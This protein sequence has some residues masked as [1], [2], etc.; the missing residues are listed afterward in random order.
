M[1]EKT[2]ITLDFPKILKKLAGY[3]AFSASE[4]LALGLTP[5]VDLDEVHR[6]LSGTSEARYLLSLIPAFSVGGVHDIRPMAEKASRSGVLEPS[7]LLDIKSTLVSS[8]DIARIFT[9]H[10][11]EF[12]LLAE[13]TEI[14]VP[15]PGIVDAITKIVSDQG[16]ILDNASQRL[17]AIRSEI[18]VAHERLL[19]RLERYISDPKTAPLLQ[20]P[21]FT[22]RNNRYVIPLRADFKGRIPAVVHDQSSSGAT[23]FIEPLAVVELNNRW[24]ELQLEERDEIRRILAQLSLQIGV[25]AEHITQMVRALAELD[26]SLMQAK[27]ADDID[28]NEPILVPVKEDLPDHPGC[29]IRLYQARHPLLPAQ[30]VVPIDVV[31]DEQTFSMVITG[32]NTGGKTVTLKTVGLLILMAQTGL[33][34]PVLSGSILSIFKNVF[35]D[36]G[37]EQ[38][39]EQSLS[40]FSGHI[41]NIIRILPQSNEHT[42]LLLDELGAGTDPQDGAAIAQGILTYLIQRRIPNLIATHYPELKS[43]AHLTPGTTNASVD[44]DLK[45]L[46]PTYHLTI[47][48]PGKSNALLIAERLGLPGEIL[49]SARAQRNPLDLRSEDLLE[50]ILRQ[51][52]NARQERIEAEKMRKD[53]QEL[54]RALEKRLDNIEEERLAVLNEA[55]QEISQ[56]IAEVEEELE[57]LRR[58]IKKRR[59]ASEEVKE[60]QT[61]LEDVKAELSH[62]AKRTTTRQKRPKR[63]YKV[64][65]RV[66][67]RSLGM[68]GVITSIDDDEEVEVQAGALRVRAQTAD[69]QIVSEGGKNETT[70][71]TE[72]A[73]LSY[74]G[75]VS[76]I[77]P[78]PG[79]ELDLRG[80]KSDEARDRLQAYLEDAYLAGLPMVRIIHGKGTGKLRETVREV[81]QRSKRVKSWEA[82]L[83][84]EGGEGV[85]VAR[86]RTDE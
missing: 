69:L 5:S 59:E 36:I 30:S 17:S 45:T 39:I 83:E 22:Q 7:E 53:A 70:G 73:S 82:G 84:N 23:L 41:T 46:R 15:P 58:L 62:Q 77:H 48:L 26:L 74:D 56:E 80:S 50:E 21:I 20:E 25:H 32:P 47:G 85:T 57:S 4:E 16:E 71:E 64:G 44:F 2:L 35:A 81:L 51:R 40:T 72:P 33:H 76:V 8:R 14:L 78:S 27:Y 68:N 60:L 19:S 63:K 66:R 24:Q 11:E 52:E 61:Q 13:V 43:F 6:R 65:D 79:L 18:K 3:A 1:D 42:L 10:A 49:E 67:L 12:P 75:R 55:R 86:M 37:D 54:R 28:A 9:Q 31:L 38:S 34:I 29:T